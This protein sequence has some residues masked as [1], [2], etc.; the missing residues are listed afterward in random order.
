MNALVV[1]YGSIGRRHCRILT[2]MGCQVSIVSQ[3][4]VCLPFSVYET[5]HSALES[6]QPD[7]VVI[8]NRTILH[9]ETLCELRA[10][11]Y[12]GKLLIEKP[13]FD[14]PKTIPQA[15]MNNL[16]V[17][18]NLRFH[19]VLMR[20]REVLES[21]QVISVQVYTG[22]H[23]STWRAG[24]YRTS[25]SARRSEGGGVLRDLSHE[26]DSVQWLFGSWQRVAAI[27]G[28]YSSLEIDSDDTF[29]LL[30]STDR[31]PLVSIQVNYLD[32]CKR[33]EM[34]INT[35]EHTYLADL[36]CNTLQTDDRVDTYPCDL[37]TT[38][39]MQHQSVIADNYEQ[40]C[41]AEEACETMQLIAMAEQSAREERWM[42]K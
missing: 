22:Q 3:Q 33:R 35:N 8:A 20:L 32:T 40:L 17:G 42:K 36:I 10:L 31:C 38:Y 9:S 14:E 7:Y 11:G 5:V 13:L 29:G 4:E 34:L 1:G 30:I 12:E 15:Y 23:L 24:D 2:E 26:L 41:T 19:P 18:Y 39:R 37:D 16:F 21:E 28:H 27:G 6:T 25:Y